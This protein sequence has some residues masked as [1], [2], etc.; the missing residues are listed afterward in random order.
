MTPQHIH[1]MHH[2]IRARLFGRAVHGHTIL[3]ISGELDIATTAALRAR[4]AA[5]LDETVLPVIIDLSRVSFCDA[6]GLTMLLDVRRRT[7]AQGRA[8]TLSGPR[9]N[10]RKLLRITGLDRAFRI[11]PALAQAMHGRAGAAVA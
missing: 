5:V 6:S 11:Y 3:T 1:G 8:I 2:T 9:P 4:I 10:V 7:G